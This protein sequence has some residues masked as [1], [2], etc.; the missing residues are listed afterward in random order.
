MNLN[1]RLGYWETVCKYA[2]DYYMGTGNLVT[3][4]Q[5][6]G[7]INLAQFKQVLQGLHQR[8]PLLQARITEHK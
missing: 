8:H 4:A 7:A 6:R 5:E 2:H 1:R 3:I